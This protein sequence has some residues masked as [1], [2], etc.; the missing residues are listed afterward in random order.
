MEITLH[1]TFKFFV[2]VFSQFDHLRYE[3]YENIMLYKTCL[4]LEEVNKFCYQLG[5]NDFLINAKNY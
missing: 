3:I 4:P 5:K 2:D 1:K